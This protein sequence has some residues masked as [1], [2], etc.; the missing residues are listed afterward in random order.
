MSGP[1][2]RREGFLEALGRG[3]NATASQAEDERLGRAS[4]DSRTQ[5]GRRS[6]R[7]FRC[8]LLLVLIGG[9]S[10]ANAQRQQLGPALFS[11]HCAVCHG[12]SGEG[13][14]APDLTNPRWHDDNDDAR[15][16][17]RIR[18]GVP[19]RAMPAF[20]SHLDSQSRSAIIA[21]LRELS[22]RSVQPTTEVQAPDIKV[23]SARLVGANGESANWLMHG[24]DYGNGRY[25]PL[26]EINRE[27][28]R[29]I[30]PV[31]SFQTGVADGLHASPLVVDGVIFLSTAWNH[32]F[33]IDARS[34][35]EIWHYRR[36]LQEELKYCC[37]PV[38]W[39]VAILED[40]L[41]LGTLDA[42]LVA[43]EARTGR[44]RWDV[45]V[46]KPEDNLS[47]KSVPLVV[48]DKVLVGVA[49]GDF[50]S[51]GFIDAYDAATG[52]RAWRFYT[53]PDKG[54]PG[55]ETW[56]SDSYKT[57]GGGAWGVGSYDPALD[58]VYWGVGQPY[59]DYDGDAREG[60][61]LYTDS[62]VALHPDTGALRWHFQY[63]PHD[64]WDWDGVNELV[65]AEL[66]HEGRQ[67]RALLHAD[68]NGH[69][70]A[71]D[72]ATGDF[73]YAEPFVRVT[74]TK[75]FEE[76]GR[77]IFDRAAFPT[78]DGVTVCPGA[79]GGK[80]WNAMAYDPVRRLAFVPA[81]ENCAVFTNY[82]VEA[83]AQGLAPRP[84]GFRYLEG[85]AYGKV[86]AIQADT[87]ETVWEVKTRTPA[88]G[89]VLAT[90]GGLALTGDGE[91][92][93]V[94][95]ESDSGEELW[96]FQTGS[97]IRAAPVTYQL[98]G[99]QYIAIAS[100]MG[101]A[102]GGYTGPG[103]PWMANH[104]RGSALFVFRLFEPNASRSFH[105]GAKPSRASNFTPP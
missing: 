105:G 4:D 57:G 91:G 55:S 54:E 64:M 95:Y 60:D 90:A 49:G 41:F 35:A 44:V 1:T 52:K 3:G 84:S 85:Q 29:N 13:A 63:T 86:M 74:W 34:G 16:H 67:V 19:G 89:G 5:V 9:S 43:I 15:I 21:H 96:S 61:N 40:T 45:E 77:P 78:Y 65:F 71:L 59:P 48:K 24:R 94:A 7:P 79:A 22:R 6:V 81:I 92:N 68:R 37:G 62:A 11:E 38:N 104:R 26:S 31:W 53:I 46:G 23:D 50:P 82:G 70:Y 97:G 18:D 14:S 69:F 87:G 98:D 47:I 76:S 101:G 30:V 103:S 56:G 102:V 36:T 58:L 8:L 2:L 25:S 100:G 51:R 33:A 99:V 66:E 39:G 12:P 17:R 75:G 88:G 80:E 93:L 83:K 32:L 20:G 73:L 27:N 28:V 72:R 42:H 10:N